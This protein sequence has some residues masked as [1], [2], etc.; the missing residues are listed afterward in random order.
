MPY[1]KFN[2]IDVIWDLTEDC[3]EWDHV[4]KVLVLLDEHLRALRFAKNFVFYVNSMLG[5]CQKIN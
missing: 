1:P 5:S 3:G 2:N 4:Q